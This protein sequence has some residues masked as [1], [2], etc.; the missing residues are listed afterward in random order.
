M[1]IFIGC[2]SSDEIA[3]EYKRD[4]KNLLEKVL[5]D[6]DLV[7]GAY[8]KGLMK[9]SYDIAK[10]NHRY[11]TGICPE[12]YKESFNVLD[13]DEEI[14]TTSIIDSTNKIYK[15]SDVIMILPGGFGSIYE[16][17]TANYC[18]ICKEL[19]KPIILY[20]SNGYYDDLLSFINKAI[21]QN[22]IN[23]KE[24]NKYFVANNPEEVI[25]YLN[26][27]NNIN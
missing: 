11:I 8:N 13:C 9:M 5:K 18:K 3:E 24:T 10:E 4:C 16:F 19:D 2:S 14:T 22:I 12:I 25:E 1:K 15:N 23:Q 6:N 27:I 26:S 21:N 7:F 20:N 17:F